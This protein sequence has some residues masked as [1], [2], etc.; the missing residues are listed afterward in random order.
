V[1]YYLIA[2][3]ASGDLHGSNLM[4]GL[5]EADEAAELRFFGGDLMLSQGGRLVKHY[6]EM[7]FMGVWEV[8][9]NLRRIKANLKFCK[10]DIL[11]YKPDVLILI[12]Y[13]GFNLRMAEFAHARGIRVFYYISPKVWAWKES[14]VTKIKQTVDKMFVIFPFEVDFYHGHGMEVHFAGNPLLDAIEDHKKNK[15]SVSHFRESNGLDSRPIVALLAG[16]RV[17]EIERCLPEM[18][19]V[20]KTFPGF[21]FVIAGAPSIGLDVYKPWIAGYPVSLVYQQTYDLLANSAA[22]VVT[23]GTATLETA[24]FNVPQV[25][26]YKTSPFTYHVGKWFVKIR[27]FSLVN[28]IMGR[29]VVKEFLQFN[30]KESIERELDEILHN[31]A[32]RN[33]ILSGYKEL[34]DISGGYGAS[35]RVA[36]LM[37]SFLKNN[38]SNK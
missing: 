36:S 15:D 18:R 14:R 7:A 5:I 23:S 11:E 24:L 33:D 3:E 10:Q 38:W 34:A 19:E 4:K 6:R 12:D 31:A 26:C 29:E 8:I 9:K 37:V 21:Q 30:L 2:G 1:K 17:Q 13:P 35:S 22:A 28:I 20:A 27:Y 32:Y 16:S 25:V